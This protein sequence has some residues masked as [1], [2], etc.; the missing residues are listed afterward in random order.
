MHNI[1][2]TF[3]T[4]ANGQAFLSCGDAVAEVREGKLYLCPPRASG[5][6]PTSLESF[7]ALCQM[8]NDGEPQADP[9][10]GWSTSYEEGSGALIISA[11]YP[12]PLGQFLMDPD[13]G[14]HEHKIGGQSV[15]V[16]LF[17]F[18]AVNALLKKLDQ[19]DEPT[20]ATLAADLREHWGAYLP[21][22]D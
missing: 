20:A 16:R 19:A 4:D 10:Q 21:D 2:I 6:A 8:M 9:G 18:Y 14:W 11:D 7:L 17:D 13:D 5:I 12:G 15:V 3:E 22:E 1:L